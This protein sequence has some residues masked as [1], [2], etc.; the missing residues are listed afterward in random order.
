[1][2]DL[3]SKRITIANVSNLIKVAIFGLLSA[4]AYYFGLATGEPMNAY[5]DSHNFSEGAI[6]LLIFSSSTLIL[7]YAFLRGSLLTF[8]RIIASLRVD[9]F[10]LFALG[11]LISLSFNGIGKDVYSKA[12]SIFHVEQLL[13]LLFLPVAL[14]LMLIFRALQAKLFEN[15]K[16]ETPSFFINDL[17]CQSKGEDLL[18]FS[19]KAER[20]AELV[21]N[22]GSLDSIVFGI[23][24]P[25]GIGKSS[26]INFCKEYWQEKHPNQI[27]LYCFEPLRYGDSENLLS[28]FIDGL[29]GSIQKQ[30]FVPELRPVVSKYARFIKGVK[31]KV[32]FPW[33]EAE[34]SP[35]TYTAEDAFDDLELVL[36]Q[37]NKKVV[38]VV[39]DLDRLS[40]ASIKR[41][42]F[43]IKKSFILP[44]ISYVLCYDTDNISILD[45]E[46]TDP[47]KLTEFFEKFINVKVGLY[48][49]SKTLEEYVSGN[50][51]AALRGNSSQAD[52]KLISKVMGGLIDI[53]RS[54]D[55]HKYLPYVGDVRKLKRLINTIML[56]EIEKTNFDESDFDKQDLIHLLLIYINY[57]GLFR[58][59]YDAETNGK[60][61]FFSA[62]SPYDLE[63]RTPDDID[64]KD[65]ENSEQYKK[66]VAD[67]PEKQ[68][69]LLERVFNVK[70]RLRRAGIESSEVEDV[71]QRVRASLACFNG[72]GWSGT[73]GRNLEEYLN[74]IVNLTKPHQIG[75]HRFFLNRKDEVLKGEFSIDQI[76]SRDEFSFSKS[77]QPREQLWKVIINNLSEFNKA[78]GQGF[79]TYLLSSIPDHALFSHDDIGLGF[80]DEL[81]LYFVRLLDQVGWADE[82]GGHIDNGQDENLKEI[83]EW[84]LGEGRHV[85]GGV[86]EILGNEQRG[87]LG[88]NDLLCFRLF[89]SADR[90]GDN[91]N[92]Q[93]SLSKHGDINAPTTGRTDIIAIEEMREISQKVFSLFSEQYISTGKNIFDLIDGLSLDDVLGKYRPYVD[94]KVGSGEVT[95]DQLEVSVEKLKSKL[96]SFIVYQLGN[97]LVSSGV[98]CGYYNI[99]GKESDE[100][101]GGIRVAMNDYL[102]GVCFEP[103]VKSENYEHFVNYLLINFASTFDR[104]KK[105]KASINEFT[106]VLDKEKLRQYWVSNRVQIRAL[107][108]T[109]SPK[110]VVTSN[111]TA[112]YRKYLPEVY[113]ILDELMAGT[114]PVA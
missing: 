23:D 25:W 67:L 92:L 108:L 49:D 94:I 99:S 93:R 29:V 20:F 6:L 50:K 56:F 109:G 39:D 112:S 35:G 34:F 8:G 107:G 79:I 7:G 103:T 24:A 62:Q 15:K 40:L 78:S 81:S 104:D 43:L 111:Y 97:E 72:G 3:F 12:I 76:L 38:I 31:G 14:G 102:F 32:S 30:V 2:R 47:E 55:Y 21:L 57:P 54:S 83:A 84:V 51:E 90:G 60:R 88:L 36:G 11:I 106:I 73:S 65:Y 70:E 46:S 91:Y 45:G 33:F 100:S 42:L 86:I 61:G 59:I 53:Y 48:L 5:L 19:K 4:E 44:N 18:N 37:I 89:C 87:I 17:A 64:K 75:Q 96:K 41:I 95:L 114:A 71:P 16:E 66:Y 80:R 1:M 63:F 98:G 77:E 58:K 110:T 28:K 13:L 105:W 52:P 82:D 10:L 69:F 26:F 113:E 68:V 22:R 74:L 27:I 9:I 85:G 101:R